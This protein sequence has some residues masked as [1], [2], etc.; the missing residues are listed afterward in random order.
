MWP[1]NP[2]LLWFASAKS[3]TRLNFVISFLGGESRDSPIWLIPS[4]AIK[5]G[6]N[7]SKSGQNI[8]NKVLNILELSA[9]KCD[10]CALRNLIWYFDVD[11]GSQ[12][13]G[14]R[15]SW[16]TWLLQTL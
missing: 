2:I 5:S 11:L 9:L 10:R 4:R 12:P 15:G 7:P 13:Y 6:P 14:R 3:E 8:K 1:A 16:R